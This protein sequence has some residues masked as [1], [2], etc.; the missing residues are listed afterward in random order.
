MERGPLLDVEMSEVEN[1]I[2]IIQGITIGNIST[3][4]KNTLLKL[5]NKNGSVNILGLEVVDLNL[6]KE[7]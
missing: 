6:E 1:S 7:S 4:S 5:R 3:D 2:A